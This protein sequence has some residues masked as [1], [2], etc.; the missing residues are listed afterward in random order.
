MRKVF[1]AFGFCAL[2]FALLFGG[3]L[4]L[5]FSRHDGVSLVRAKLELVAMKVSQYRL[6]H[7]QYPGTLVELALPGAS[8]QRPYAL[9]QELVDPWGRPFFYSVANNDASALVFSLGLDGRIGGAGTDADV[10]AETIA[11]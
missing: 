4:L 8:G 3:W 1:A 5:A 10:E 2:A 7:A 9:E 11:R 6:E